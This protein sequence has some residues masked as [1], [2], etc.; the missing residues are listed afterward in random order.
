MFALQACTKQLINLVSVITTVI[1][2]FKGYKKVNQL[3]MHELNQILHAVG[4]MELLELAQILA[5]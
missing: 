2:Q 4:L 5:S 3:S 1:Y